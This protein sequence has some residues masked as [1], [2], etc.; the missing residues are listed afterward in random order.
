MIL[1]FTCEFR[2][3][4][5]HLYYTIIETTDYRTI[6]VAVII[7]QMGLVLCMVI[8]ESATNVEESDQETPCKL[9]PSA[10]SCFYS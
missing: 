7:R 9:I 1:S 2:L 8:R 4:H 10:S 3:R 6:T 5:T